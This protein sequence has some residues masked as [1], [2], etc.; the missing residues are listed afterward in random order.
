MMITGL[1]SSITSIN[2]NSG[3]NSRQNFIRDVEK[4]L[5]KNVKLVTNVQQLQFFGTYRGSNAGTW[6]TLLSS[7][8]RLQ[9][10]ELHFWAGE[11]FFDIIADNC[12]VGCNISI[13]QNNTEI[14]QFNCQG[15]RELILYRQRQ[16]RA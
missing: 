8:I 15:L 12:Q 6:A 2:G 14:L 9:S 11:A 1:L 16:G 5:V 3:D 10:L 4:D 7:M 13:G